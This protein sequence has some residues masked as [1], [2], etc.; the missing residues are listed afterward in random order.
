MM[1]RLVSD[2]FCYGDIIINGYQRTHWH[3]AG[4]YLLLLTNTW[5]NAG[6]RKRNGCSLKQI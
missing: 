2:R 1:G 5:S 6:L 4:E 3:Y